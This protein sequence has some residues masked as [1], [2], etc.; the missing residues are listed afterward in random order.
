MVLLPRRIHEHVSLI[1]CFNGGYTSNPPNCWNGFAS[2]LEIRSSCIICHLFRY[3][4][5]SSIKTSGYLVLSLSWYRN[6]RSE[7]DISVSKCSDTL[8]RMEHVSLSCAWFTN[9]L[10]EDKVWSTMGGGATALLFQS[11]SSHSSQLFHWYYI[12]CVCSFRLFLRTYAF[13]SYPL[14]NLYVCFILSSSW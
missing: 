13:P 14:R 5:F 10:V 12:K 9:I 1:C 3:P 11:W 7:K 2:A 6:N 4:F 8:T